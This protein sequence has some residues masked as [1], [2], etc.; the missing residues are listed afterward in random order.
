MG[1]K[2]KWYP[3]TQIIRKE[4]QNNNGPFNHEIKNIPN[5]LKKGSPA[6]MVHVPGKM[7]VSKKQISTNI[8]EQKRKIVEANSESEVGKPIRLKTNYLCET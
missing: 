1:S 8:N 6:K 4:P 2:P 3:T 5:L 7:P